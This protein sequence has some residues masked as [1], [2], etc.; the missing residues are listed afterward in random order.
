MKK[1][2]VPNRQSLALSLRNLGL[3][4]GKKGLAGGKNGLAGGKK[5]LA[6]GK[7]GLAGGKKGLAGGKKGL[8]CKI[9]HNG[10]HFPKEC[11]K[12]NRKKSQRLAAL[13]LKG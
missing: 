4:G 5:G 12:R 1:T 3:A 2:F 6:G 8:G 10:F 7:K 13:A 11:A 9:A